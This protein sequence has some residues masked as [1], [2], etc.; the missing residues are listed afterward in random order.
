MIFGSTDLTVVEL[1]ADALAIAIVMLPESFV[2]L[3]E[4]VESAQVGVKL[5]RFLHELWVVT[6]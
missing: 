6:C 5:A 2:D 3:A 1:A 4:G